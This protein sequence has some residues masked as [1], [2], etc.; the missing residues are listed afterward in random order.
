MTK[1]KGRKAP[2]NPL[3]VLKPL[4]ILSDN[5]PKR[6]RIILG[7]ERPS[8]SELDAACKFLDRE[9]RNLISASFTFEYDRTHHG[10]VIR[11]YDAVVVI[12]GRDQV[13]QD[14]VQPRFS[15]LATAEIKLR[16][17][18]G[19]KHYASVCRINVS[20]D[21]R[22]PCSV[23]TEDVQAVSGVARATV[24]E[25]GRTVRFSVAK[26]HLAQSEAVVREVAELMA[27]YI[28]DITVR[29]DDTDA[30]LLPE[31]DPDTE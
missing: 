27:A 29:D 24:S 9:L 8:Y 26:S 30:R 19:S 16:R 18:S 13:L 6:L 23:T 31:C 1:N 12:E 25:D 5:A 28:N 4:V 3:N 20:Y 15:T 21:H 22:S 17:G 10:T 7:A 14:I 11:S 2:K